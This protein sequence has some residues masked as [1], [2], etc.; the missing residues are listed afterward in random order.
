MLFAKEFQKKKNPI[1][2]LSADGFNLDMATY[3]FLGKTTGSVF[4]KHSQE[5]FLSISQRFSKFECNT[6]SDWL[7]SIQMLLNM[8]NLENKTK[9]TCIILHVYVQ[10]FLHLEK[11]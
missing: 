2:L 1:I 4:T 11:M 6:T 9:K 8:K 5:H 7:N 3:W 10:L